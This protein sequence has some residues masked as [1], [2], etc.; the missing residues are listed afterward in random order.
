MAKDSD[1]CPAH[2]ALE[3]TIRLMAADVATTKNDVAAIRTNV[4]GSENGATV[5]LGEQVRNNAAAIATVQSQIG[6]VRSGAWQV[7]RGLVTPALS[8][9]FGAIVAMWA[10][11]KLGG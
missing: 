2:A 4:C 1:T 7:V 5:G 3:A 8:A 10:A 9:A 11:L 6:A